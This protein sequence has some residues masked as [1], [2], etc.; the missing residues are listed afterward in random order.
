MGLEGL[1]QHVRESCYLTWARKLSHPPGAARRR[2]YLSTQE[3]RR[4]RDQQLPREEFCSCACPAHAPALR[5]PLCP[6]PCGGARGGLWLPGFLPLA[7]GPD[8]NASPEGLRRSEETADFLDSAL[9]E[10]SAWPEPL[11]VLSQHNQGLTAWPQRWR[12]A[13]PVDAS[14]AVET[15]EGLA[16][17]CPGPMNQG[18]LSKAGRAPAVGE[19]LSAER[20]GAAGGREPC[21]A[22]GLRLAMKPPSPVPERLGYMGAWVLGDASPRRSAGEDPSTWGI[23]CSPRPS[24]AVLVPSQGAHQAS[25]SGPEDLPRL[26]AR[27]LNICLGHKIT[28]RR[29]RRHQLCGGGEELPG[30]ARGWQEGTGWG[31]WEGSADPP[32]GTSRAGNPVPLPVLSPGCVVRGWGEDVAAGCL[33]SRLCFQPFIG[34]FS[35]LSSLLFIPLCQRLL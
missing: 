27:E 33:S 24:E 25:G 14:G 20:L 15:G 28:V 29:N 3:E 21:H 12:D 9:T 34:L 13:S 5:C 10:P 4:A 6:S 18:G 17:C 32:R 35:S 2:W 23:P 26:A 1:L 19:V 30:C 22:L 11:L 31:T 8:G 7:E 16:R